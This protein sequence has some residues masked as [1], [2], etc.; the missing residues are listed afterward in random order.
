MQLTSRASYCS[1][2]F[3][4]ISTVSNSNETISASDFARYLS[5]YSR[6][7]GLSYRTQHQ[8]EV[9]SAKRIPIQHT[10]YNNQTSKYEFYSWRLEYI[11]TNNN[12]NQNNKN[13]S[14]AKYIIIATGKSCNMK[15]DKNILRK[16]SK[17]CGEIMYSK[18]V[19]DFSG[20]NIHL[21]P[22]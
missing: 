8:C 18:D 20:K 10:V 6:L 5:L 3:L 12:G 2:P 19:K 14:Y 15:Q 21:F 7:F 4:P 22:K 13:I 16:L 9:L 11:H 1:L 17:F